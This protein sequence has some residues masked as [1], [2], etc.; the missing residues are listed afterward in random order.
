[1]EGKKRSI[2]GESSFCKKGLS[3]AKR[4]ARFEPHIVPSGMFASSGR[5]IGI[6]KSDD[7][8]LSYCGLW[9]TRYYDYILKLNVE[10]ISRPQYNNGLVNQI[11]HPSLS[12]EIQQFLRSEVLKNYYLI[13]NVYEKDETSLYFKIPPLNKSHSI[14][15]SVQQSIDK[16][17]D[18]KADYLFSL[19]RMNEA[20]YNF[21]NINPSIQD[22]IEEIIKNDE[23]K[24]EGVVF[25]IDQKENIEGIFSWLVGCAFGN[26]D[27][28]FIPHPEWLPEKKTYS[29]HCLYAIQGGLSIAI[30]FRLQKVGL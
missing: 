16:A 21:F 3:W 11:P 4:T 12:E 18:Q 24:I 28:R 19:R 15:T 1:M 13:Q 10:W 9:N 6:F 25:D 23:A 20:V 2:E 7:E 26:W 17:K 14:R 22:E 8:I 30:S 27:A 5:F 29:H